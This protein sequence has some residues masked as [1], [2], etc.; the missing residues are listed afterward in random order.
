MSSATSIAQLHAC[1]DKVEL[2]PFRKICQV[3]YDNGNVISN[4]WEL[5]AFPAVEESLT[6]DARFATESDVLSFASENE[7]SDLVIKDA[8]DDDLFERLNRGENVLLFYRTDWTRHLLHKDMEA[9]KYAFEAV[10]DRYK[11]VIWDR[12]TINGGLVDKKLLNDYGFVTDR[13]LNFQYY[14]LID[15]CDKIN[16]DGFPTEVRSI[17]SGIDKS[18]RDRFDVTKFGYSE[19]RPEKT[20]RHF[21]YL[22]DLTVGKG[23]LMV[24]AFN[25]TNAKNDPSV[26]AILKT[27][28]G[29]CHD[30]SFG[31]GGSIEVE[32][33]RNYLTATADK[34]A[35]REGMMTQ[36]WQLDAEPV[37][38]YEYW[39]E[40]E[41]YLREIEDNK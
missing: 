4:S 1:V 36:Y 11:A 34:G 40:S 6:L 41:K 8:L 9:P 32:E 28:V 35:N 21:S 3:K 7:S 13:D 10:W 30:E 39:I 37:E 29:I 23:K 12:G 22:F 18:A 19:L 38:S 14:N 27:M 17:V 5:W 33:L 16:L 26:R 20:M 15:D 25:M 24:C 2:L 31:K